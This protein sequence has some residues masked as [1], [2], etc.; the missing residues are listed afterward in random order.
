MKLLSAFHYYLS[1]LPT[2]ISH[3]HLTDLTKIPFQKITIIR[4]RNGY[5][6]NVRCFMDVW[7]LKE[8]IADNQYQQFHS[9]QKGD[10]VIDIGSAFGDFC[11]HTSPQAKQ[12]YAFDADKSV[13]D[14][15]EKNLKLNSVKNVLPIHQ[16]VT[17]LNS[18]LK[19]HQIAHCHFLKIDCEG[20]EYPVL[21]DSPPS[22]FKK[23]DYLAAE[24]HLFDSNMK[25]Q[26]IELQGHLKKSGFKLKILNNPVHSH[27]KLLFASK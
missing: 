27:L 3:F 19:Q 4:M 14:L 10:T 26:F 8:I 1:S 24:I 25:Q 7:I 12:I 13:F 17:N 22:T 15:M 9:V 21:L 5:Q 11:T 23:V 18:L 2:L 20:C 6:F 16:Q